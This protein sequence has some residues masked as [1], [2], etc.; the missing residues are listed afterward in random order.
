MRIE[1]GK[2]KTEM[3]VVA[4]Y[5]TDFINKSDGELFVLEFVPREFKLIE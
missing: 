2:P 4:T 1:C 5:K 3:F